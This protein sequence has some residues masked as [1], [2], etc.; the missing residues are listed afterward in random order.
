MAA[1]GSWQLYCTVTV[2]LSLGLSG[3]CVEI[4]LGQG[5]QQEVLHLHTE[6]SWL[7]GQRLQWTGQ[8]MGGCRTYF[9]GG[10]DGLADS[11]RPRKR[12]REE[13]PN[14]GKGMGVHPRQRASW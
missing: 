5:V 14:E 12:R 7:G 9:G 13:L 2:C 6:M 11:K 8:E 10:V 3:C 1:R 4:R